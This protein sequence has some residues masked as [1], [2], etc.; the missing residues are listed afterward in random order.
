MRRLEEKEKRNHVHVVEVIL[1]SSEEAPSGSLRL[2]FENRKLLGLVLSPEE[3]SDDGSEADG[4]L[5][6]KEKR[7]VRSH[8]RWER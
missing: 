8:F 2:N 5:R 4:N 3:G 1:G 6:T 7:R